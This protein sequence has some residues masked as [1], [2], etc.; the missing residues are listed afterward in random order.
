MFVKPTQ[1]GSQLLTGRRTRIAD[2]M[3][4]GCD[5]APVHLTIV[6]VLE[7]QQ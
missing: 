3:N 6:Q 1:Q 5:K 7:E 2:E 4:N